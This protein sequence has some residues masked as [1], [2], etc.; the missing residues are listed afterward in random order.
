MTFILSIPEADLSGGPCQLASLD[1]RSRQPATVPWRLQ[2]HVRPLSAPAGF[3]QVARHGAIWPAGD[4]A[5][6]IAGV[7]HW[8]GRAVDQ[9]GMVLGYWC[10][11]GATSGPPN[12][13]YASC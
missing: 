10:G 13:C 7:Q 11:A 8:L 6:K 1:L 4:V 3:C 12:A 2:R 5:I 9:T